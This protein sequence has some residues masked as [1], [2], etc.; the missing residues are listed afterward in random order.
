[1]FVGTP[2]RCEFLGSCRASAD[3]QEEGIGFR[4]LCASVIL[5]GIGVVLS[6]KV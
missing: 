3:F 2:R 4:V 6:S 5:A 1:M